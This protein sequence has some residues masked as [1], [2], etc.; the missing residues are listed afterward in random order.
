[1]DFSPRSGTVLL[2][3]E[4]SIEAHLRRSSRSEC[5][6]GRSTPRT[7]RSTG[8]LF[9]CPVFP[10]VY[11]NHASMHVV[12]SYALPGTAVAP[13]TSRARVFISMENR[14]MNAPKN[15]AEREENLTFGQCGATR[16]HPSPYGDRLPFLGW[17][18]GV[19]ERDRAPRSPYRDRPFFTILKNVQAIWILPSG[20]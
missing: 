2:S 17:S 7:E 10:T 1:M 14:P 20:G 3:R 19:F 13:P 5:S 12:I 15:K 18:I 11:R 9:S 4:G 16:R 6:H 8:G